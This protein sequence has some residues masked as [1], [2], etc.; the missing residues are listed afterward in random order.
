MLFMIIG[1]LIGIILFSY[2]NSLANVIACKCTSFFVMHVKLLGKTGYRRRKTKPLKWIKCKFSLFCYV[3][4]GFEVKDYTEQDNRNYKIITIVGTVIPAVLIAAFPVLNAIVYGAGLITFTGGIGTGMLIFLIL[5]ISGIIKAMNKD[6]RAYMDTCRVAMLQLKEGYSYNQLSLPTGLLSV[7]KVNTYS[8]SR[9]L[10]LLSMKAISQKDYTMLNGYIRELDLTFKGGR[11]NGIFV[12]NELYL[13]GY[14]LIMYYST[15]IN[16][17]LPNAQKI[18]NLIKDGL[19]FLNDTPE[20]IILAYY[21]FYVMKRP[22]LAALTVNQARENI[23]YAG[24]NEMFRA[25]RIIFEE[26]IDTLQ[27]KMTMILN[28]KEEQPIIR[29]D[30]ENGRY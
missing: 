1:G 23:A 30:E 26:M 9:Y 20:I 5:Y 18:Y 21:Q 19:V 22:D 12:Y 15:F 14:M 7:K 28:P 27:N 6:M 3:T 25:D 8:R 16:P 10:T 17:N 29:M 4:G 13:D 24:E 11:P 2:I